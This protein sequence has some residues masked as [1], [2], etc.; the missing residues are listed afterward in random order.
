MPWGGVPAIQRGSL[1][2]FFVPP[3]LHVERW[4]GHDVI[5]AQVRVLI[6]EQGV[7]GASSEVEVDT[8]DGHVH[9]G[10][11]PGGGVALLAID[12]DLT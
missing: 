4:V 11:P 10:Q 3:L 9:R 7:G 8:A 2:K 1:A 12:A 6:V 5:G